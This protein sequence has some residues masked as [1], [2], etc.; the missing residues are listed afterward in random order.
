MAFDTCAG[1]FH[2]WAKFKR[3]RRK[4]LQKELQGH[5]CYLCGQ[6]FV[7]DE[8]FRFLS[9]RE[10]R[11]L[12]PT[13]DHV[14]PKKHGGVIPW[15]ILIAH[16][17]CNSRRGDRMPHPCELIALAGVNLGL[18]FKWTGRLAGGRRRRSALVCRPADDGARAA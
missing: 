11:K 17:D 15:N 3:S 7:D 13:E 14:M 9:T 4:R 1:D 2:L 5:R 12:G 18:R 6:P 8:A 10:R 16:Q